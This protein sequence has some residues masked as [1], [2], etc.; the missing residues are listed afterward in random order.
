MVAIDS[1]LIWAGTENQCQS[2]Q[3]Q[4][5]D[6]SS[7]AQQGNLGGIEKDKSFVL[8]VYIPRRMV[9]LR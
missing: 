4:R 5:K 9:K 8:S 3:R 6:I 2:L 7:A 1:A